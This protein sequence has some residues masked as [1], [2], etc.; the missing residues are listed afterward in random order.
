MI[1]ES[2]SEGLFLRIVSSDCKVRELKMEIHFLTCFL[3]SMYW[4]TKI[5]HRFRFPSEWKTNIPHPNCV[6]TNKI[7]LPIYWLLGQWKFKG[8]YVDD[9]SLSTRRGSTSGDG[10]L[11]WLLHYTQNMPLKLE[12]NASKGDI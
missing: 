1:L 9:A 2:P 10:E 3:P 5:P 8:R 11:E 12:T 7:K 6:V 4:K